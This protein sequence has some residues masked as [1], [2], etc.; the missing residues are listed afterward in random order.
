V[1]DRL[2][3]LQL[4]LKVLHGVQASGMLSGRVTGTIVL[5]KVQGHRNYG[6]YEESDPGFPVSEENVA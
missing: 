2:A 3:L 5:P 4:H 1:H 6:F